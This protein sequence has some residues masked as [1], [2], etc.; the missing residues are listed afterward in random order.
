MRSSGEKYS[1][2]FSIV[3]RSGLY[4]RFGLDVSMML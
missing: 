3:S 4:V 1:C 2:P